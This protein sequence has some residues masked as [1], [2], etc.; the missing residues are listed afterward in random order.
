[1]A[2][3]DKIT[4]IIGVVLP[5]WVLKQFR[6]RSKQ[7]SLDGKR[8]NANLVYLENKTAWIRLVSSVNTPEKSDQDYFRNLGIDIKDPVSYTHLTLPTKA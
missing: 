4:N 2:L 7:S 8:S 5:D 6:T 3:S 1:M